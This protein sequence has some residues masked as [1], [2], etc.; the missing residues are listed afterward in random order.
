M[1]RPGKVLVLG[2][3]ALRIGQAGEFDYS[4]SQAIKA[5]KAEGIRTVLVNPNIATIQTSAGMA[6]RV[7]LLAVTPEVAADINHY[8]YNLPVPGASDV[9]MAH[10][11]ATSLDVITEAWFE[12][13]E[14]QKANMRLP[15]YLEVVR[16]DEHRFAYGERAVIHY[17]QEVSLLDG[18]QTT[19]KIFY[20][21]R[22]RTGLSRLQFQERWL[23]GMHEV[24][25]SVDGRLPGVARYVQNHVLSEAEHPDGTI[26]R[27]KA[28]ALAYDATNLLLQ[29]I[30]EA[31]STTD[32]DK[33]K[34]AMEKINYNGVSGNITYDASHNPVKS[35]PILAVKGGKIVVET[36]VNP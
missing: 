17:A 12:S 23:A 7:Y 36:V 18:R 26:H 15:R 19:H 13:V 5:L 11:L 30:K 21:R 24:L 1:N 27:D 20:L 29:A 22:R 25:K 6:D 33:V 32:T 34:A 9:D 2:S 35:A 31:G 8:L 10:P 16:P 3:G 28:A 4:G 14:A